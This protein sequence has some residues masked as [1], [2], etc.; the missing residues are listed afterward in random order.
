M[1]LPLNTPAPPSGGDGF[2]RQYRA[3]S[4][5]VPGAAADAAVMALARATAAKLRQRAAVEAKGR[6]H[7]A[8]RRSRRW[9]APLAL[10][11]CLVLAVGV[12]TRMQTQLPEVP[13]MPDSVATRASNP[14]LLPAPKSAAEAAPASAPAA[15]TTPALPPAST[16]APHQAPAPPA[17]AY[18]ESAAI[19]RRP[20]VTEAA[21]AK[22]ADAAGAAAVG[23]LGTQGNPP[24]PPAAAP[25]MAQDAATG[26][27]PRAMSR[28]A[29]RKPDSADAG[30]TEVQES[31][32]TPQAWLARIVELRSHGRHG[33]ADASL[34]RFRDRYPA[35][36]VPAAASGEPE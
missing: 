30:I 6:D 31:T 11:A 20:A 14:P 36:Q 24:V 32:L 15:A 26:G 23:N 27:E 3:G 10:A 7:G 16:S 17:Q 25:A 29:A 33:E 22:M 9:Q 13:G 18:S 8:L 34:K 19:E 21:T 12:V 35:F 2:E 5:E 4:Q 28:M 1:N